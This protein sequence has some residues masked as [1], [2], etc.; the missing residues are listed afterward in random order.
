METTLSRIQAWFAELYQLGTYLGL[1]ADPE[2]SF[3][4][5][6]SENLDI[7]TS[8]FKEEGSKINTVMIYLGG[9]ICSK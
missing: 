1:N 6:S 3:I 7:A 9:F 2:K 5:A 4:I 8:L